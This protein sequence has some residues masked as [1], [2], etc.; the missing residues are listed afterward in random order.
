MLS[1]LSAL[2]VGLSLSFT[3]MAV[4]QD[5]QYTLINSSSAVLVEFY[6]GPVTAP[7]W[8]EDLLGADVLVPGESA[9]VTI[10]DGQT[11]CAYDLLFIFADNTEL[12]DTVD[13]CQLGSYELFD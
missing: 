10:A 12:T 6:T 4:A 7:E 2:C 8:G 11:E 9:T 5:V 13:I 3:S 1:R